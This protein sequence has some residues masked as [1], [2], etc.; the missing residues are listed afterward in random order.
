MS[1]AVTRQ[2][3]H[4]GPLLSSSDR[5][6]DGGDGSGAPARPTK[7][8][9]GLGVCEASVVRPRECWL[10]LQSTQMALQTKTA[11]P[12]ATLQA[13]FGTTLNPCGG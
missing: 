11:R 13:D 8:F 1:A 9:S 10:Q 6:G 4:Q 2:H 7:G 12:V 3:P 5:G